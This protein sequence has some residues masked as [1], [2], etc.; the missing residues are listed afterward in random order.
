MAREKKKIEID[1]VS[2]SEQVLS[3]VQLEAKIKREEADKKAA[4]GQQ[5]VDYR[6]KYTK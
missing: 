2:P 1:L 6:L 4:E 3:D 5:R